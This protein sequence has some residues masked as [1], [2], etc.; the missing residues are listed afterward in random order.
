MPR[1]FESHPLRSDDRAPLSPR[2]ASRAG[3]QTQAAGWACAGGGASRSARP[4]SDCEIATQRSCPGLTRPSHQHRL[5]PLLWVL[6]GPSRLRFGRRVFAH[7]AT[8]LVAAPDYTSELP[9]VVTFSIQLA[10]EG[11]RQTSRTQQQVQCVLDAS[12]HDVRGS[13][14]CHCQPL[15]LQDSDSQ[16]GGF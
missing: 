11:S 15:T 5:H 4:G 3:N 6:A 10:P 12:R 7:I 13:Q 16:R 2:G 8:R 9:R 1:G 14:S